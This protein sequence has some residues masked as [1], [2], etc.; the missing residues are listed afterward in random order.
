M[1]PARRASRICPIARPRTH[2]QA[3]ACRV[4]GSRGVSGKLNAGCRDHA[5][6]SLADRAHRGH[7]RG[8]FELR[9]ALRLATSAGTSSTSASGPTSLAL[10]ALWRFSPLRTVAGHAWPTA[11]GGG[12]P[13]PP[14]PP[15]PD[16][17]APTMP[18]GWYSD[19]ERAGQR[20]WQELDG[21]PGGVEAGHRDS[22]LARTRLAVEREP[23][24]PRASFRLRSRA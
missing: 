8:H 22:P 14:P 3:G 11:T 18:A 13:Q 7:A 1:G 12:R 2:A 9:R 20:Y 16:E 6:S 23:R 10:E 17:A 4:C 21:A 19:P 5:R 15:P 24:A